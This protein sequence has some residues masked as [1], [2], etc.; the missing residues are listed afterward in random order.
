VFCI[1]FAV[2]FVLFLYKFF[3]CFVCTSVRLLPPSENSIAV[4]NND[5]DDDDGGGG[6]NNN[7]NNNNNGV[8][9][10]D[11]TYHTPP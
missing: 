4:C 3:I 11:D 5:D 2:Y 9:L 7:N 6:N 1:V 8:D 10:Q